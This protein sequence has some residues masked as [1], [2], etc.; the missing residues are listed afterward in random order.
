VQL[1]G[2]MNILTRTAEETRSQLIDLENETASQFLQTAEEISAEV[3]RA[4][5]AEASLSVRADEIVLSVSDL[6]TNTQS[7][8][9]QLANQ[10][11]LCVTEGEVQS[12]ISV[13]VGGITLSASQI[14]LRGNTTIND[15]LTVDT[16][17]NVELEGSYSSLK[18][19]SSG[20]RVFTT[21][22]SVA[23]TNITGSEITMTSAILSQ[24]FTIASV[25]LGT[26]TIGDSMANV[27]CATLNGGVPIT[28]ENI[29]E[30]I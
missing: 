2:K 20:L 18:L 21:E 6:Q 15:V 3:K 11:A 30:Y 22:S 14:Y 27:V 29:H 25:G 13:A 24:T 26:V 23:A 7:S 9:T 16:G 10:I 28:S 19:T 12:M 8:I 1:K 5:E 17:G 4:Q